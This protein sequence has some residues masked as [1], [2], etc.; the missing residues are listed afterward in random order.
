M[1]SINDTIKAMIHNQISD[2]HTALPAKIRSYDPEKMRAEIILLNKKELNDEEV[3]IPPILEV[4]VSFFKAGSFIIRPPY[5][6][7]DPV[8]A[9]FS[10]TA[11]DK[12]L[13]SGKVE[14]TKYTRKFSYDD[15][16]IVGGLKIEQA[17]SL[18]SN[19]T[20]DLLIENKDTKDKIVMKKTGNIII[21][22]PSNKIYLGSENANE[23]LSLGDTLKSWLDS[24][25]HS[26]VSSGT[27]STGSPNSSSPDPSEKVYTE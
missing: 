19:F 2:I 4:P 26:G 16:I 22:S 20:S 1:S 25:S 15:A 6:K 7:G 10:E 24:H 27:S 5:E 17:S 14:N 3:E 21:E 9:V 23:P 12:L 13:I 11:I 8:L 18:N